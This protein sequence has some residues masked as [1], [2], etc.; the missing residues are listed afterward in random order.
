MSLLLRFIISGSFLVF[1]S[2]LTHLVSG[3]PVKRTTLNSVF[4]TKGE[5]IEKSGLLTL[6]HQHFVKIIRNCFGPRAKFEH[7]NVF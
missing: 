5:K 6:Q 7:T 4:T 2:S 3:E 1:P